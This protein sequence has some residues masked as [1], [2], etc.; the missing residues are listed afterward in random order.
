MLSDIR[1][2]EGLETDLNSIQTLISK[3]EKIENKITECS[4]IIALETLLQPILDLYEE[5][6]ELTKQQYA[7]TVL[8]E[9]MNVVE[10]NIKVLN[11]IQIPKLQKQFEKEMGTECLLCG[12]PIKNHKH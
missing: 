3:A 9:K 12:Q 10:N 4:K 6:E 8:I 11:T 7:L 2:L 1:V 5:Q